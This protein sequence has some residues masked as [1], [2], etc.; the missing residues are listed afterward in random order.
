MAEPHP[1]IDVVHL[2]DDLL[3]ESGVMLTECGLD[4]RPDSA[5]TSELN[6]RS[7]ADHLKSAYSQGSLLIEVAA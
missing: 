3:N 7:G 2:L 5:A 1:R 6:M 4:P